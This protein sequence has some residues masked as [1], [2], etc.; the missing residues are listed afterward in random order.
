MGIINKGIMTLTSQEEEIVSKLRGLKLSNMAEE[1]E[2]QSLDPNEDIKPFDERVLNIIDAEIDSR[3]SK[4]INKLI[5]KSGLK[6]PYASL[7]EKLYEPDRELNTPLIEELARCEWLNH[8]KNLIVTGPSGTGKTYFCNA[9]GVLAI[10]HF[11]TVYYWRANHLLQELRSKDLTDDLK[12]FHNDLAYCDLLIIDDFGLMEISVEL[13]RYLL[14]IL[15]AREGRAPTIIAS[16]F[17]VANW[18]NLFK[19]MTFADACLDRIVNISFRL[20]MKG[21]SLRRG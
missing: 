11:K 3:T 10:N 9:L 14:D 19:D 21:N 20:E 4:K 2:R 8:G 18:Y 16:Q 1:F 5:K 15:D 12:H 7:D 13:C 17:P 6:Y